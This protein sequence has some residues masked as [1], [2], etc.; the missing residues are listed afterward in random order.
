M[1]RFADNSVKDESPST[2][3]KAA[4][5]VSL[6]ALSGLA[7]LSAFQKNDDSSGANPE[8]VLPHEVLIS[9]RNVQ[10]QEAPSELQAHDDN[11]EIFTHSQPGVPPGFLIEPSVKLASESGVVLVG[12]GVIPPDV[13]SLFA[14]RCTQLSRFSNG[15]DGTLLIC[16]YASAEP[17]QGFARAESIFSAAGA[18][19]ISYLPLPDDPDFSIEHWMALVER[20]SG[21]FFT[22]GDQKRICARLFNRNLLSELHS[23]FESGPCIIGGTSAGTAVMSPT[24]IGGGPDVE[25]SDW[26]ELLLHKTDFATFSHG[27]SVVP[28]ITEQHFS[29]RKREGRLSR[30]VQLL[31][32]AGI[33]VDENTAVH[34]VQGQFLDVYGEGGVTVIFPSSKGANEG[35]KKIPSGESFDLL[36]KTASLLPR[37]IRRVALESEIVE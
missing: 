33:G 12:G 8:D 30:A 18:T 31:G 17:L 27:I 23:R 5:V 4:G 10:N 25:P 6:V 24:M 3:A 1:G 15:G 37:T 28:F 36:K 26:P 2:S 32:Q 20:A 22:G 35:E 19:K 9:L 16:S 34:F 13:A 14:E 21:I 7:F 29:Q 11:S